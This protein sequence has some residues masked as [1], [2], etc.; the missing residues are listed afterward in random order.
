MTNAR[1]SAL[2]VLRPSLKKNVRCMQDTLKR[3]L[4]VCTSI[5]SSF[6]IEAAFVADFMMS[7][8]DSKLKEKCLGFFPVDGDGARDVREVLVVTKQALQTKC[9]I[10]LFRRS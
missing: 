6:V 9:Q 2:D 10:D 1:L 8:L 7:A 4:D 3:H 5:D